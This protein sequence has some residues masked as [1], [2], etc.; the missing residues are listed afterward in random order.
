VEENSQISSFQ[1]FGSTT[2]VAVSGTIMLSTRSIPVQYCSMV[3]CK[4]ILHFIFLFFARLSHFLIHVIISVG[5]VTDRARSEKYYYHVGGFL[6]K[7]ENMSR[8]HISRP[9]DA[10]G[11][12]P[13]VDMLLA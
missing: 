5:H 9:V 4:C 13:E 12:L 11:F 10:T 1:I 2:D 8:K 3:R 7:F 6:K